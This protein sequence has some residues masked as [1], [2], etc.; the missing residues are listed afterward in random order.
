MARQTAPATTT[1]ATVATAA[2]IIEFAANGQILEFTAAYAAASPEVK[3]EVDSKIQAALA[4]K[5]AAKNDMAHVKAIAHEAGVADHRLLGMIRSISVMEKSSSKI[6]VVN[7]DRFEGSKS[8]RND[9]YPFPFSGPKDGKPGNEAQVLKAV[10]AF[11][12][13]ALRACLAGLEILNPVKTEAQA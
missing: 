6:L 9:R 10:E 7:C 1:V 11:K 8:S 12:P 3:T 2:E 4:A 13:L 5:A